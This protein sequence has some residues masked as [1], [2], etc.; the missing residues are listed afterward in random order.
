[1][2]GALAAVTAI[3]GGAN[4]NIIEVHHQRAF[5]RLPAQSADVELVLQTRGDAH[6]QDVLEALARGGYPAQIVEP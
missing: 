6:L 5:T 4:A 1:M 3:V 2:P